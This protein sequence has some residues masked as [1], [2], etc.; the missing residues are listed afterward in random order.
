M[1]AHTV[2]QLQECPR[3]GM[4]VYTGGNDRGG[5]HIE[6]CS[7]AA[8]IVMAAPK[9]ERAASPAWQDIGHPTAEAAYAHMRAVLLE[10]L[11]MEHTT[12]ADWSGCRAPLGEARCDVPTKRLASI[13]PAYFHEPLCDEHRT[14]EMVEAMWGGPGDWSGSW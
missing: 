2:Q 8:R 3:A 11:D 12:L 4:Y 13:E 14:R 7:E 10:R 9:G 1:Q 5:R 6:C